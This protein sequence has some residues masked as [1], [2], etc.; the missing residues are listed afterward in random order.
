MHLEAGDW[1]ADLLP[2]EGAAFAALTWRGQPVLQ[3]L[4][5]RDPNNTPAGAFWMLPWTNR[6]DGGRFP[7]AGTTY[8]FPI[9]HPEE[10][11]A[12]HGLSRTLPWQVEAQDAAG[13]VLTQSLAETPF[14][15]AAR[16]DVRLD[17]RGL[18]L[19]M[20]LR[21]SGAAPCPM[22]MGW[23]PWFARPAGCRVEFAARTGFVRDARKLPVAAIPGG[24]V[25]GEE[26]AWLGM[27]DHFAGWD[28][29]VRLERP[30]LTLEL[31]AGGD[32][33][34]NIQFYAPRLHPVLCLEP[35]SH[36]PDV[37]NRP[38]FSEHGA[39]RILAPGEALQGRIRLAARLPTGR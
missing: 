9:T 17:A 21:N 13:A 12:L 4:A 6:I 25:A 8:Q 7:W 1:S 18:A 26:A 34:R 37:I 16:L 28:G 11:N 24:G 2:Q 39:M 23:H 3:P 31:E 33:C 5:G 29:A 19:A 20:T 14:H 10:G 27:D 36:V 38:Q 32:W 35:V 15:Y 30:E 22:G